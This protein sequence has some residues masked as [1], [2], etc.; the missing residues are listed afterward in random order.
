MEQDVTMEMTLVL[1]AIIDQAGGKIELTDEFLENSQTRNKSI[2][3]YR[4]EFSNSFVFE[5]IDNEMIGMVGN[6]E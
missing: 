5:L 4:D 2:M 3:M 6:D 1:A